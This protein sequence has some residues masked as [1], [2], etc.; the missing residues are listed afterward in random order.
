[1]PLFDSSAAECAY[2]G[3]AILSNTFFQWR[4]LTILMAIQR[5]T[6]EK[7]KVE[8]VAVLRSYD[9]GRSSLGAQSE[10]S[11][12]VTTINQLGGDEEVFWRSSSAVTSSEFGLVV[13]VLGS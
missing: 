3:S 12:G 6:G 7:R 4:A 2:P 9:I 13:H 10:S 1:M 11:D 5:C 8:G